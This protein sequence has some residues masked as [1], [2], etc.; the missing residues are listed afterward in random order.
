MSVNNNVPNISN[1]Q[2]STNFVNFYQNALQQQ[3]RPSYNRTVQQQL[4][5]KRQVSLQQ[6]TTVITNHFN[7]TNVTNIKS[8]SNTLTVY[9][10]LLASSD[11]ASLTTTLTEKGY[12][13]TV[14]NNRMTISAVINQ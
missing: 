8:T 5:A 2:P 3:Q 7:T 10:G 1:L 11:I 9:V 6:I 14:T 13:T 12:N 4:N